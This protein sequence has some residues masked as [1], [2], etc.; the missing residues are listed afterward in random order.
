MTMT[1]EAPVSV[2]EE[3][4]GSAPAAADSGKKDK[5]D[6]KGKKEKGAK[7]KSNLI[8]AV[9]LA[10]GVA[11]GGYFMGGGESAA[12]GT[13][14][15][16]P[17]V[18]VVEPGALVSL[19]PMTLNLD[20]G[21]FLRVGVSFLMTA[22]FESAEGKEGGAHHFYPEDAGPLQDQLIAMFAW[23]DGADLVGADQLAATKAEL[24]ERANELFDGQVLEVYLT[25][26][27][28]Q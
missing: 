5:K 26:F 13:A 8:P 18:P 17:E 16:E 28:M 21:R 9:V 15:A 3:G 23:R 2:P 20:D 24:L 7:G 27:V 12:E 11:A 10:L 6:K 1:E 22:E 14:E 25:D 19:D 4:A